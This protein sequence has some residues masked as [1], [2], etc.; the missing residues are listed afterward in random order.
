MGECRN[1]ESRNCD[2][3]YRSIVGVGVEAFAH[4][5]PDPVREAHL[6]Q[7]QHA[8]P[9]SQRSK[10]MFDVSKY[11]RLFFFTPVFGH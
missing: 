9:S 10:S 4:S 2:R 3:L 6:A 1:T 8:N 7:P 11:K 5:N